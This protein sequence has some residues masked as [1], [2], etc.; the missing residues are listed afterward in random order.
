MSVSSYVLCS[1]V[2]HGGL[3]ICPRVLPPSEGVIISEQIM[4]LNR[5]PGGLSD[6][7]GEKQTGA[8]LK[9]DY[10]RK[11]WH[12]EAWNKVHRRFNLVKPTPYS[13]RV[14]Y[15]YHDGLYL[16]FLSNWLK[17]NTGTTA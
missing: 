15:I 16:S 14:L 4:N 17:A 9:T 8:G 5:P 12:D 6:G 1:P 2:P 10:T 11:S 7:G 3:I 13:S